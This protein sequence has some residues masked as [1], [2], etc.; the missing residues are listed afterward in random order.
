[1]TAETDGNNTDQ[2]TGDMVHAEYGNEHERDIID[3]TTEPLSGHK[4]TYPLD[5]S[6]PDALVIHCGDSRFQTAFRR[7]I[8]GELGITKYTPII[9]GGGIHALGMQVFLP[10]NFKI[11]WEQIKFHLK[12]ERPKQ[13]II[14]N[15]EDCA[16][17]DK[18]K[19]YHFDLSSITK[20][21]LDLQRA[22]LTIVKDFSGVRVRTFWAG[23]ENGNVYF[24]EV[25]S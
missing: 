5:T 15:H 13:V 3:V 11:L 18:M 12:T 25:T 16:W 7:F 22:A 4:T 24:E 14:I 6:A 10:K 1:M 17:Y 21:K 8:S 20:G 2:V 19:G 9:I 23:I